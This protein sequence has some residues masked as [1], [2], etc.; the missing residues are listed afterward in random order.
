[1]VPPDQP[2]LEFGGPGAY[3]QVP[4]QQGDQTNSLQLAGD[5]EPRTPATT[6]HP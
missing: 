2:W 5:S 3:I 4:A 6:E 1:M